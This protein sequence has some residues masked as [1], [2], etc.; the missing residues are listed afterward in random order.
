[1]TCKI[2]VLKK[3]KKK[4]NTNAILWILDAG[5]RSESECVLTEELSYEVETVLTGAFQLHLLNVVVWIIVTG[6]QR[7]PPWRKSILE[8]LSFSLEWLIEFGRL[9]EFGNSELSKKKIIGSYFASYLQFNQCPPL[10]R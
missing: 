6:P 3:K 10:L 4:V 5:T 8:K 9:S 7:I 1:M 2:N